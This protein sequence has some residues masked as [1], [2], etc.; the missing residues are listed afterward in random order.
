[1]EEEKGRKRSNFRFLPFSDIPPPTARS[2]SFGSFGKPNAP[3]RK[4]I[5]PFQKKIPEKDPL[6]YKGRGFNFFQGGFFMGDGVREKIYEMKD[7]L[8]EIRRTIHM[9]PELMF[10]EE[11]TAELVAGNLEKFGLEVKKGVAKTGVVGLLRGAKEGKTV[12]I[13]ADMDALPVEEANPVC[14]PQRSK[15]KC[16]PAATMP[17]PP[18]FWEWPN[19]SPPG[20]ISCRGTSSGSSSRPRKGGPGEKS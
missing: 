7:W 17:I 20:G 9:H 19:F 3:G 18:S 15:E 10:E 11:K 5:H 2:S 12:A 16:M 14:M 6:W 4:S 1:L 13:R 8:V